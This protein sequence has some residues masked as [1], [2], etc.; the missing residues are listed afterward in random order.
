MRPNGL[1]IGLTDWIGQPYNAHSLNVKQIG[2][3]GLFLA[4]P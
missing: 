2:I 4:K 1:P 3:T